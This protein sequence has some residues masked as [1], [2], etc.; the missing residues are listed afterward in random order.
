MAV[1]EKQVGGQME[2]DLDT[3]PWSLEGVEWH[4]IFFPLLFK[5]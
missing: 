4:G 3:D 5:K 1:L 2:Q